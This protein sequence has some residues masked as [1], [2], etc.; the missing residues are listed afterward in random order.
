MKNLILVLVIVVLI[1]MSQVAFVMNEWQQA[2]ITQLGEY[3][4]AI[5]DPGI[6]YRIPIL[7]QL[8]RFDKRVLIADAPPGEYI[9]LDKKRVVVDH[10]S[11]WRIKDPLQFFRTVRDERGAMARL[12][13]VIFARLRQEIAGH[14]FKDF[15]REKREAIL[16]EVTTGT[17]EAAV[18]FGIEV[19]DVRI[20]RAD[21]PEEVQASVFSRMRAER[22]RIAQRYR[23]EGDERARDIRAG[24]DKER[25]IILAQAYEKSQKLMGTG[26]AQSTS[27]YAQA[28]GQDAEFY[29]F[30]RRLETYE[31]ILTGG[32][33]T[34]VL[35]P[36]SELLRYLENPRL[37]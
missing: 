26:D 28:L 37:R 18:P 32:G 34:L 8:T 12:D 5:L 7:Q 19:I 15:I 3:K 10:V 4:R 35:R 25:E 27:I 13:D 29:A 9:T 30:T 17:Q 11:R 24:A 16:E 2:I 20:K 22:N 6:Y 21:L 23:A 1:V 36:D 33:T 14:I 31:K